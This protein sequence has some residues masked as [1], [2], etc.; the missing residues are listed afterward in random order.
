M[1]FKFLDFKFQILEFLNEHGLTKVAVV[2][3]MYNFIVDKSFNHL[4]SFRVSNICLKFMDFVIQI[5][6]CSRP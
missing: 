3:M 4:K 6:N 1:C 5:K 2:D